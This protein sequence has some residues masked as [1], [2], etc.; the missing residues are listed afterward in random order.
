MSI[1]L[2]NIDFAKGPVDSLHH[3]Y[4]LWRGK[5]I[6]D[7]RLFSFSHLGE[8]VLE[9]LVFSKLLMRLM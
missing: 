9:N 2:K 1:S 3:D 4:Y 8:Q 6:E 5:N 7:K